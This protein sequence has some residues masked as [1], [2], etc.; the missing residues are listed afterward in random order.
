MTKKKRIQMIKMHRE[1]L[2]DLN[3]I[4]NISVNSETGDM[5]AMDFES[6][7]I[8][9]LPLR[10]MVLFPNTV[11]PVS[12]GRR[13][14]LKLV[15]SVDGKSS[16]IGVFCQK[17]AKTDAPG[18]N[19]LYTLGTIAKI[20]RVFEMPDESTTV[21]LQG[22]QRIEL[23]EILDT[24]PYIVGRVRNV[25]D[26]DGPF[27]EEYSQVLLKCRDAANKV[28]KMN[29]DPQAETTFSLSN[30]TPDASMINFL[31]ANIRTSTREKIT[32]LKVGTI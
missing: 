29:S 18:I 9:V 5:Q 32:L 12:I 16:F 30:A 19:D 26:E 24:K 31:C 25:A 23:T 8:P 20:A 21:I 13:S 28:S 11:L 7:D 4:S 27:D 2:E 14:S 6:M 17:D 15:K 1:F 22:F 3:E 10:N